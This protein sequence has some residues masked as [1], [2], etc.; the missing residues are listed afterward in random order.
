[1][2]NTASQTPIPVVRTPALSG[3]ASLNAAV[4]VCPA[5]TFYATIDLDSVR[6]YMP[7]VPVLLPAS[8]WARKGLPAPRLPDQVTERAADCGGFVATYRHGG[9]YQY[10]PAQYVAW[11]DTGWGP[12]WAAM[13]DLCCENEITA[14]R[15]GLVRARQQRTTDL[16]WH[17]WQTYRAAP[18]A[19][20]PTVQGWD[21]AD[22]QQHARDLAPL[23]A[24][25]RAAYGSGSAFRVGIGTL[26]R[27]ASTAQ[28]RA[29]V[30]AVAAELPGVRFHLWGVKLGALQSGIALP[31]A[32]L[33]VDS[34][35]WNGDFGSDIGAWKGSGLRRQVWR[36]QVA[37]PAYQAKVAAALNAPK[38][39]EMTL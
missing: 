18:W 38:Q 17:F 21:V 10:T 33:S 28:I 27:R 8:S 15:P 13:M 12:Q 4:G 26:C 37:L 7:A 2:T 20:V 1:M 34:A 32:V 30:R 29:I 25:M 11:L 23:I 35:A 39:G 31:P 14:G 6:A 3:G 22:Y 24:E 19:W 36:Y 16:A 5:V 9:E